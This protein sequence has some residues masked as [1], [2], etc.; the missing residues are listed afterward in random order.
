MVASRFRGLGA[1]GPAY[2]TLFENDS[3][4]PGSV[5]RVLLSRMVRL[6]PET[7]AFWYGSA[8]SSPV[9]RPGDRPTRAYPRTRASQELT[10]PQRAQ[11]PGEGVARPSYVRSSSARI[12]RRV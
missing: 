10:Q 11:R 8:P 3:H 9:Y 12:A 4:A 7:R 6:V 1:F 5:D 2:R